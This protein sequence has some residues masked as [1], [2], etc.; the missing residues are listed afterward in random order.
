MNLH[1]LHLF[2]VC[3]C[4]ES[5]EASATD[6]VPAGDPLAKSKL[7]EVWDAE[8]DS[9]SDL[10]SETASSGDDYRHMGAGRNR[11]ELGLDRHASARK[12]Q[13]K[14][15]NN[16]Q[17]YLKECTFQPVVKGLPDSYGGFKKALGKHLLNVILCHYILCRIHTKYHTN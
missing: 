6:I 12:K 14:T 9:G 3:Y 10:S 7:Q 4:S 1:V 15:L 5:P 13:K 2:L 17:R 16:R 8:F 11:R